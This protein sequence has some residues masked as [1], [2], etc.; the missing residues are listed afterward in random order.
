MSEGGLIIRYKGRNDGWGVTTSANMTGPVDLLPTSTYDMTTW[1]YAKA[2]GPNASKMNDDTIIPVT[3]PNTDNFTNNDYVVKHT[4]EIRSTN[5]PCAGLYL[6]EVAVTDGSG[7]AVGQVHNV[8]LRVGIVASYYEN[9]TAT[10]PVTTK[11]ITAPVTVKSTSATTPYQTYYAK[12]AESG[13]GYTKA[14][15]TDASGVN[16]PVTL[17]TPGNSTAQIIPADNKV[18]GGADDSKNLV[19]VAVYIWYEGEDANLYSDNVH[20]AE[21]LKITLKFASNG[22]YTET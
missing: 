16:T 8:A 22:T 17:T 21:D 20:A 13:T 15:Y 11:M 4:F 6:E 14:A 3:L 7:N 12:T 1:A 5:T 9:S 10:S 18:P 19:T 2:E